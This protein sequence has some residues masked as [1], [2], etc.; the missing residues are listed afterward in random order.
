[1]L[2]FLKF[3]PQAFGLD[4]SDF[5]A[6]A[7]QLKKKGKKFIV[8]SWI[9][10]KIASGIIERGVI[11]KESELV[12]VLK[13]VRKEIKGEKI[14]T[15]YAVCSLPE[16]EAFLRVIQLP[17]NIKTEDIGKMLKYELESYIPLPAEELYYDFQV[18]EGRKAL[19]QLQ[20]TNVLVAAMPKKIVDVYVSAFKKADIQPCF[21]EI[22]SQATAR[23]LIKNFQ[24]SQPVIILDIGAS[25]TG[26]TI[27]SGNTILLT[28]HIDI[29]GT[30]FTE[31]ISRSLK[32][33]FQEAEKLKKT[34]ELK[35]GKRGSEVWESLIPILTSLS[36]EI[37]KFIDFYKEY[38]KVENVPDGQIAKILLCGGD[39]LIQG[40]PRF[41]EES[42]GLPV[43]LGNSWINIR[44]P[45]DPK[46]MFIP[47]E[48]PLAFT[49]AIGLALRGINP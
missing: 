31:L 3:Q 17:P 1:M 12:E 34:F 13:E 26:W 24:S 14:S 27:F 48:E 44:D 43:E 41:L 40:F 22:E 45:K 5:S 32:V 9:N 49:T 47:K 35:E 6:K 11:K 46:I 39:S 21:L 10:K 28:G 29:S 18:L 2:D 16:E 23:A 7:V 36:D 8:S 25:G 4:I 20:R 37:R 30:N 15:K 42:L 19:V 33:D 38:G